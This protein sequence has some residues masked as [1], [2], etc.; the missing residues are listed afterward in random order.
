MADQDLPVEPQIA[1]AGRDEL[2]RWLAR[3]QELNG[4]WGED[5]ELTAA[6]LLAY[7]RAGFTPRVGYYRQQTR[8]A[9][10]W[11][12]QAHATGTVAFTCAVVL[13]E[14]AQA[15]GEA[16]LS[17]SARQAAAGLPQPA[18]AVE[19]AIVA[20]WFSPQK[21][22][23]ALTAIHTLEDLRLA[24]LLNLSLAAPDELLKN[25][26]GQVYAACLKSAPA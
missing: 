8:R 14:L 26:L 22:V 25:D 11:L 12:I 23:P 1:P 3:T 15:T 19:E 18:T 10:E 4:S 6:A 13:A 7:L 2:L 17:Q 16:P 5:I 9:A 21:A 20:Y 24:A